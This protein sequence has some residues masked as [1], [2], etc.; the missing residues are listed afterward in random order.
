MSLRGRFELSTWFRR[1]ACPLP[2]V[3]ICHCH[4]PELIP[5]LAAALRRLPADATLHLTSSRA[6]VF[7]AWTRLNRSLAVRTRFHTIENRGRD[8]RPFFAV[9]GGLDLDPDA[10][11]LKIHGKQSGY[12]GRGAHWRQDLLRGLVRSRRSV[13]AVAE[14]FHAN[15]RLG[16]LGAPN[17]YIS[18]PVYWGENRPTVGGVMSGIFGEP[19][20]E[21]ELG[22][23][24][25]S[26]LWVR[27]GLLRSLVPLVDL[28]AFE[29]EPLPRDGSY[30]H[31]IE[32]IMAMAARRMGWEMGEIGDPAPLDPDR[33]R[34]RKV[35]YL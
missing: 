12:T 8:I 26:M 3:A 27:G 6:A 2:V 28:D 21:R 5:E 11:V 13:G 4:H 10:L 33:I 17:S 35:V 24:A 34:H 30:A 25:G 31:A 23:F 29:P 15:P 16:M 32:R 1:R 14:R 9:A 22:F 20:D 7:D 19:P 18:H